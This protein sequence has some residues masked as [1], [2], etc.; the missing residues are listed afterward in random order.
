MKT[1]INT[2]DKT[3][4]FS[5]VCPITRSFSLK[6]KPKE[7]VMGFLFTHEQVC[8]GEIPSLHDFP[9]VRTHVLELLADSSVFVT[10]YA[11]GSVAFGDWSARSDL[12]MVAICRTNMKRSAKRIVEKARSY[13]KRFHI[14]LKI[15]LFT[16]RA[17]RAGNH[18]FGPSYRLMWREL[19]QSNMLIGHSPSLFFW[20][21]QKKTVQEEMMEKLA[22]NL[23]RA[24]W[25]RQFFTKSTDKRFD[26]MLK[27]WMLS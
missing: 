2:L 11:Y 6:P 12:D 3:L 25:Q 19:Q 21:I 20:G 26:R 24:K 13:A 15:K 18:S 1:M 10:A 16:V 27:R 4:F 23:K 9:R 5:Y 17:A 8:R 14:I 22:R 7:V